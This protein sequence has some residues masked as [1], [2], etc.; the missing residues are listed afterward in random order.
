MWIGN[1][2]EERRN[3]IYCGSTISHRMPPHYI[4]GFPARDALLDT[5]ST[6]RINAIL[7]ISMGW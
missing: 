6:R 1:Q 4:L 3:D 7:I 2:S 5:F